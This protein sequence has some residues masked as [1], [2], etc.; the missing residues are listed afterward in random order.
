MNEGAHFV[1]SAAS[2][3]G[4]IKF[5]RWANICRPRQSE[6]GTSQQLTSGLFLETSTNRLLLYRGC[7]AS[8]LRRD[9]ALASV[10]HVVP[11]TCYWTQQRA[12]MT[13]ARRGLSNSASITTCSS[14]FFTAD[15]IS[16][17]LFQEVFG[18]KMMSDPTCP[19]SMRPGFPTRRIG[20]SSS[21][22]MRQGSPNSAVHW[23]GAGVVT[24]NHAVFLLCISA[25]LLALR[26]SGARKHLYREGGRGQPQ[27]PRGGSG[28]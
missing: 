12:S 26:R 20:M 14:S 19:S 9:F 13:A 1:H 3:S 23:Q 18:E 6:G 7:R 4:A 15:H 2:R 24:A 11:E 27:L 25:S 5:R 16:N 21:R 28:R 10:W 17:L 8:I 22:H